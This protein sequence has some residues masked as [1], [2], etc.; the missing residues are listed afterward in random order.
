MAGVVF[1][2]T[3]TTGFPQDKSPIEHP[4]QP[5]LVQLAA[6]WDDGKNNT[7]ASISLIVNSDC[8]IPSGAAGVHGLTRPI[9]EEFGVAPMTALAAFH[10]LAQRADMLIAHNLQFD[11]K[12]LKI[13]YARL[14]KLLK[15]TEDIQSKPNFCTMRASTDL[16]K[17]PAPYGRGGYKW[18]KLDEA[19]RVLVNSA[20]F[21]GAHD[22]MADT[23][24]CREVYYKLRKEEESMA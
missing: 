22:A 2:D 13:A 6:I 7:G 20:G 8:D 5:Y 18:P 17:I 19:Y 9:C 3:E 12:I 4:S 16:V 15:F 23:N 11:M 14:G 10:G 21:E 24:A 1:F